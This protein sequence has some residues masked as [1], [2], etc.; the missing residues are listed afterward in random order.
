MIKKNTLN[1]IPIEGKKALCT[2]SDT[3][4]DDK[5]GEICDFING[6]RYDIIKENRIWIYILSNTHGE[7]RFSKRIFRLYFEIIDELEFDSG[8]YNL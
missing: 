3:S 1:S 7:F 4:L 5:T 2:K 6:N 8:N